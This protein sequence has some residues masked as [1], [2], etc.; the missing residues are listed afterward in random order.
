ML[1]SSGGSRR[2]A[3]YIIFHIPIGAPSM[4]T[5]REILATSAPILAGN[6]LTADEKSKK[7]TRFAVN[8]EMWRSRLPYLKGAERAGL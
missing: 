4:P 2:S 1:S 6:S 7:R 8:S 3:R 5:H